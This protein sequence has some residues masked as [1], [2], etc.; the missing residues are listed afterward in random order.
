VRA[1]NGLKIEQHVVGKLTDVS[2]NDG[3]RNYSIAEFPIVMA[4]SEIRNA[5]LP[6]NVAQS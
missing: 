3:I 6:P 4:L 1:T 2:I 5:E